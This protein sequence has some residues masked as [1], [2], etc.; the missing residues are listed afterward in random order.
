MNIGEEEEAPVEYPMPLAPGRKTVQEPSPQVEPVKEPAHA[1]ML[2]V[3]NSPLC[4]YCGNNDHTEANCP[5]KPRK[6]H[7]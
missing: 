6:S 1:L 3:A 4:G 5:F 2:V 7:G